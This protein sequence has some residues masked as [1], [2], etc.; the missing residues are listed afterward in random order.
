M[1][2]SEKPL[3]EI[4]RKD[5]LLFQ[6]IV[7]SVESTVMKI[8]K[9]QKKCFFYFYNHFNLQN[10]LKRITNTQKSFGLTIQ[11]LLLLFN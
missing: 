5:E 6:T 2:W 10:Y 11:V 9:L 8:Q 3:K 4:E 7:D 1:I